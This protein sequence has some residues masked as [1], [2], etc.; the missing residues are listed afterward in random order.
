MANLTEPT[1][2]YRLTAAQQ[3]YVDVC[4]PKFSINS[5]CN[6]QTVQQVERDLSVRELERAITSIASRQQALLSSF[7][8]NEDKLVQILSS[9]EE[10]QRCLDIKSVDLS[11][12]SQEIA[13]GKVEDLRISLIATPISPFVFPLFRLTLVRLPQ[14][15]CIFAVFHHLIMDGYAKTIFS[16]ELKETLL[17]VD[18]PPLEYCYLDYLN[19]PETYLSSAA[20]HIHYWKSR[21][22][23]ITQ[24]HIR[25][26][27]TEATSA[28]FTFPFDAETK[29]ALKILRPHFG[30][31]DFAIVTAA[32]TQTLAKHLRRNEISA[33]VPVLGRDGHELLE[34]V[35]NF[36]KLLP[37][38]F[39]DVKNS[40]F[41]KLLRC[42]IDQI[43]DGLNH[44]DLS[45]A[46]LANTADCTI[47]EELLPI[48]TV[49]FNQD[50]RPTPA[51]RHAIHREGG[52]L[53]RYE[54][55]SFVVYWQ[56]SM[57]LELSY[58]SS[59]FSNSEIEQIAKS[60]SDAVKQA[61]TELE[62]DTA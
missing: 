26:P 10:L 54:L 6:V 7:K 21:L 53:V 28:S 11:T 43:S 51:P 3:L 55:Q 30:C 12:L 42:A 2:S 20:D 18:L 40:S 4:M 58:R 25:K 38:R 60:V 47:G 13:D 36:F 35:G 29:A 15:A 57:G 19:S 34:L 23:G 39:Q 46:E 37:L 49:L 44:L 50:N 61:R 62:T 31:T 1:R 17:G 41:S 32:M 22:A 33:L 24:F 52:R 59:I 9:P 27:T 5:W 45:F 16:S 14:G 56:D 8:K 48:S